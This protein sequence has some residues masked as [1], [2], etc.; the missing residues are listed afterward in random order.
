M[1]SHPIPVQIKPY[2]DVLGIDGTI[3]FLLEFGGAELYLAENPTARSR[4]V[5]FLGLDKATAL[6]RASAHLP[7]RVPLQKPWIAQILRKEKSLPVSEIARRLHVSDVTVRSYLKRAP[8]GSF[9]DPR[10]LPLL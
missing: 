1:T 3:D 4:L 6:S 9:A 5:Q 2:V 10:Q 8:R 7:K